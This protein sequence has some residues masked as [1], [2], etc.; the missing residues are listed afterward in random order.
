[1]HLWQRSKLSITVPFSSFLIFV[2]CIMATKFYNSMTN[3]SSTLLNG[4]NGHTKDQKN[5]TGSTTLNISIVGAGIG[6][7]TAAIGLRRNGHNVSV[8]ERETKSQELLTLFRS[9]NSLDLLTRQGPQSILLPIRMESYADTV[10]S[11]RT[12]EALQ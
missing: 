3:G 5:G 8:S 2:Y 9:M 7:L 11:Q 4:L 6:G 12:L 1:M 10:Y